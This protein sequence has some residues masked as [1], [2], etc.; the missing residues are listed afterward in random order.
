MMSEERKGSR[1]VM[2]R[3]LVPNAAAAS[4]W[5]DVE[6]ITPAAPVLPALATVRLAS[7]YE[8]FVKPVID[9]CAGVVLGLIALPIAL[10]VILAIRVKLGKGVIYRQ[11]RV[12]RDGEL[13]TMYKFRTMAPDRRAAA[14]PYDG[15]DRRI[16]HKR[17]DDPRHTPFG[18]FLRRSSLDELPQLWNVIRGEMSLVGPRPELPH[19]V[20][21]YEPWQHQRHQVKPGITGFWQLS[22]RAGGLAYEG[23]ELDLDYL[24][25]LSFVTDLVVLLRT[26]PVAVARTGR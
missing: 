20:E 9:R 11:Q 24:R 21:R 5:A 3:G 4:L 1:V 23:V 17:D 10:I 8:R 14:R 19:I 18:R 2:E 7:R 6:V 26:V 13:F 25:A 15:P 12:G 16:C 22:G